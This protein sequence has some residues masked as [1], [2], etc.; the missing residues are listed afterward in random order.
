MFHSFSVASPTKKFAIQGPHV[1]PTGKIHRACT[2][3]DALVYVFVDG[4]KQLVLYYMR[5]CK[6]DFP[7]CF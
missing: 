2:R 7:Q 1:G 6:S 5:A 4:W 3:V